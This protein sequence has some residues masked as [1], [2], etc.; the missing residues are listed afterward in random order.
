MAG[1]KGRSRRL[2]S[3]SEPC[4]KSTKSPKTPQNPPKKP[5][6]IR[7]QLRDVTCL[8]LSAYPWTEGL[9]INPSVSRG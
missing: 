7:R 2:N 4:T 8:G 3:N 5:A 9:P 6:R 1:K